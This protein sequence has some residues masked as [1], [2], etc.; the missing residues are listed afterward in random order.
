MVENGSQPRYKRRDGLEAIELDQEVSIF[1]GEDRTLMLNETAS[2]IWQ[3]LGEEYD[4]AT[5]AEVLSRSY[6]CTPGSIQPDIERTLD[7]LVQLGVAEIVR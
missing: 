5:I 2:Q 1:N 6:A 3:L 4:A 7:E